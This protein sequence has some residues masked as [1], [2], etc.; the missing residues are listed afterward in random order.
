MKKEENLFYV[1]V[2][3]PVELRRVVL[4][5]SKMTVEAMRRFESFKEIRDQKQAHV[6]QLKK[7]LQEI[8][9]A[10]CRERVYTKV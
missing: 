4:E 8:G 10:S 1:G 6:E 9:R 2:E 5:S 7:D 3:N